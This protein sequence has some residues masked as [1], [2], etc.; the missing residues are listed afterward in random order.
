MKLAPSAWHQIGWLI[1]FIVLC[2]AAAALGG[3]ATSSSVGDWYQ[4]LAKP[5]WTPPA[6]IFGPVW[7]MLFL[8]M[9]IAAWL[10]WRRNG[11]AA[12]KLPLGLFAIQLALN[13][14]W[15]VIF[16][17]LRS[18][19]F[20][21]VEILFLWLAIAFTTKS[22]WNHSRLAAALMAPYL[23]WSTFAAFLN[24]AIFRLDS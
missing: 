4:S 15:S 6:W 7:S 17:G 14:G 11:W 3:M 20:A 1:G 10:V 8:M 24:L 2:F 18:P 21:F 12:A 5:E 16:F 19:G 13:V 22:F 9:A 23:A